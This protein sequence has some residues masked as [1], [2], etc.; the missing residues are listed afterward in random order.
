M[1]SRTSESI[2]PRPMAERGPPLGPVKRP[3]PNQLTEGERW[4]VENWASRTSPSSDVVIFPPGTPETW[5]RL[6]E[7]TV[8]PRQ[9]DQIA[10]QMEAASRAETP[11]SHR[12]SRQLAAVDLLLSSRCGVEPPPGV[13]EEEQ[14][15]FEKASYRMWRELA[16]RDSPLEDAR[17][18]LFEAEDGA[19]VREEEDGLE[20]RRLGLAQP[21]STLRLAGEKAVPYLA[22]NLMTDS[23]AGI[24][25]M[26]ELAEMPSNPSRDRA[27]VEALFV[28]GDRRPH[29]ADLAVSSIDPIRR[30]KMFEGVVV[31][32]ASEGLRLQSP[33]WTGLFERDEEAPPS[34]HPSELGSA[35][36][37]LYDLDHPGALTSGARCLLDPRVSGVK[38]VREYLEDPGFERFLDEI[39]HRGPSNA[40]ETS[41]PPTL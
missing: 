10:H 35:L 40:R 14:H 25:A 21:L 6:A 37:L 41:P 28:S 5:V 24:L 30:W 7:Q 18:S 22:M 12:L 39:S 33:Y 9:L 32:A 36:L 15:R 38:G 19:Y 23:W 3:P 1:P 34:S 2:R 31:W 11:M 17:K 20:E 4:A 29:L 13:E 26:A 16:P 8:G 27:L